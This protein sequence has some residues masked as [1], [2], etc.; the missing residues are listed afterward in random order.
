MWIEGKH[1]IKQQKGNKVT[2]IALDFCIGTE[3][4]SSGPHLDFSR[5]VAA[6]TD[7]LDMFL[8][9]QAESE[10]ITRIRILSA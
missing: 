5:P 9:S 1:M 8:R 6:A 3:T 2:G 4:K 10:L 7:R